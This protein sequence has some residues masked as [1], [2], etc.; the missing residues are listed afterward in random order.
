MDPNPAANFEK[1]QS[2]AFPPEADEKRAVDLLL[3]GFAFAFA[4]AIP[5]DNAATDGVAAMNAPPLGGNLVAATAMG[6]IVIVVV[7][8]VAVA[9]PLPVT[10]TNP[11]EL[12]PSATNTNIMLN[13]SQQMIDIL[14][15]VDER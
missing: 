5:F 13:I 14:L 6:S 9:G 7:V 10:V 12:C 15:R 1:G 8:A 11:S 4:I 3:L 2:G